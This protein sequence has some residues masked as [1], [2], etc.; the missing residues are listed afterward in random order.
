MNK[1]FRNFTSQFFLFSFKPKHVNLAHGVIDGMESTGIRSVFIRTFQDTGEEYG[2]PKC[3]IE[4]VSK[5]VKEVDALRNKYK[6]K[7]QGMLSIWTDPVTWSTTK[8]GFY[9]SSAPCCRARIFCIITLIKLSGFQ[10]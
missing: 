8:D 6:D 7:D 4:P 3:F 9:M 10:I 2:M 5:V 1:R